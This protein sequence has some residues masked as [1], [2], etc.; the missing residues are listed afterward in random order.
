MNEHMLAPQTVKSQEVLSNWHFCLPK[1]KVS[2]FEITR[3]AS[4]TLSLSLP[5]L[6]P[7]LGQASASL[8]WSISWFSTNW[9]NSAAAADTAEAAVEAPYTAPIV[10]I[11]Y[12]LVGL[13]RYWKAHCKGKDV[14]PKEEKSEWC[15]PKGAIVPKESCWLK[16]EIKGW[17]SKTC[18]RTHST[19]LLLQ[20]QEEILW[21]LKTG[22]NCHGHIF[23]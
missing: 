19:G 18:L 7:P 8:C 9:I 14:G 6:P 12:L 22:R 23:Q 17:D 21:Q 4:L 3:K 5:L 15:F 20:K 13:G 2:V 11:F 16:Q 10:E 1:L